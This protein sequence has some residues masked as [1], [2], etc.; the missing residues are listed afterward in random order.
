MYICMYVFNF[1]ISKASH[2]AQVGPTDLPTVSFH[3][4]IFRS[5]LKS[6]MCLLAIRLIEYIC[7]DIIFLT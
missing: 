6:S 1:F 3:D 5:F 2:C 7:V 4:P